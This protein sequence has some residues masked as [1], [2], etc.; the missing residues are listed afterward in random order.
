MK[1]SISNIGWA[2]ELDSAVYELMQSLSFEGL[3][4]APTRIFPEAPYEKCNEAKKWAEKLRSDYG[5][6]ISS[7][8][9]IWYG[10]QENMFGPEEDRRALVDYTKKAVDF[11]E[12]INCPN[13][14]FGC[15]RNRHMPEGADESISIAFFREI[16]D[17]AAEHGAAIA[18][19]AVPAIYNTNYI[20]DTLIAF[21][22]IEKVD[23]KGF[24]LN[25][26]VG[27]LLEN[28]EDASILQGKMH[29]VNHVHI[30]EPGLKAIEKRQIHQDLAKVL[31]D[32]NYDKFVSIEVGR[33]D[34]PAAI[35]GML[36]YVKSIFG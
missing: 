19:E 33:Q 27:S 17:Y 6:T 29:L 9:S 25:L 36:Q 5:F 28:N 7:A 20:N 11:A 32:S 34:D 16:G 13:L 15:P 23:S 3:E 1:L 31:R 10:R 8:Q 35:E 21:D 24:L 4:M 2:K 22:M 18:L 14:V 30:S 12:A 26:D